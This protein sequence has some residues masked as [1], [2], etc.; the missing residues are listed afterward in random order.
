AVLVLA[1]AMGLSEPTTGYL[2]VAAGA[3][4]MDRVAEAFIGKAIIRAEIL[5]LAGSS[6]FAG[7][8]LILIG[9]TH[10]GV[11]IPERGGLH[12][13]FMGGLGLGVLAVFSI[14]GLRHTGQALGFVRRTRLAMLLLVG[15]TLLRVVPEIY[16]TAILPAPPYM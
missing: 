6:T 1:E 4:L 7:I 10:L 3:A 9:L 8:G 14:A 2:F 15:A 13:A 11:P 12:L 5:A 16:P